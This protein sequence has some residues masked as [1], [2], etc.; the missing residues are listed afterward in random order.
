MTTR[1]LL[2]VPLLAP[3]L[4]VVLVAALNPGPRLRFRL[5]TWQT[6]AAPLGIWLAAAALGG[7]A[8]S[9]GAAGLALRQ[10]TGR[11]RRRP[12]SGGA[13]ER[14]PWLREEAPE[15]PWSDMDVGP[16]PGW[17]RRGP[18]EPAQT[19]WMESAG[20]G[21]A[22]P[23]VSVAPARAPG[24]PAPTVV[25]PFRVLRRPDSPA[26]DAAAPVPRPRAQPA[27]APARTSVAVPAMDDW[28]DTAGAEDW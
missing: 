14:E 27:T 19:P 25:V 26:A 16:R 4:A 23:T 2:V 20:D 8:L 15:E 9:G 22:A 17:R 12:L 1:R 11:P 6:P 3:L 5:L 24:E 7:A 10:E 28:G 21:P 18:S 13:R